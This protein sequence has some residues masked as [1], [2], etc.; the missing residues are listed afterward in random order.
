MLESDIAMNKELARQLAYIYQQS[1]GLLVHTIWLM[2]H[3]GTEA[4]LQEQRMA[5]AR[6]L[7]ELGTELLYPIYQEYPDLEPPSPTPSDDHESESCGKV[8]E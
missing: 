4:Q 7:T 2:E 1:S 6:V 5:V 3:H 8:D